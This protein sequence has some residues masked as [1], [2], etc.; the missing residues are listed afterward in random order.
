MNRIH[1]PLF[2]ALIITLLATGLKAQN[3]DFRITDVLPLSGWFNN[4]TQ[5]GGTVTLPVKVY[6]S[7]LSGNWVN[8]RIYLSDDSSKSPSDQQLASK[9][10]QFTNNAQQKT[11]NVT[12]T[13]P[14]Y[15]CTTNG[16]YF[17]AYSS[18]QDINGDNNE[19]YLFFNSATEDLNFRHTWNKN[20]GIECATGH[21]NTQPYSHEVGGWLRNDGCGD[22]ANIQLTTLLIQPATGLQ[23]Q[24]RDSE[25]NAVFHYYDVNANGKTYFRFHVDIDAD[26]PEGDY[27]IC[28]IAHTETENELD[29]SNDFACKPFAFYPTTTCS[30][31]PGEVGMT[32]YSGLK[33]NTNVLAAGPNPTQCEF[34]L[35]YEPLAAKAIFTLTDLQG[36]VISTSSLEASQQTGKL[37]FDLTNH[38]NGV[39]VIRMTSE[40]GAG[41]DV[42]RL[43]KQ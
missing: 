39:Y 5:P 36:R 26:L 25:T 41:P 33:G 19:D 2:L 22:A 24:L 15:A 32:P 30:S 43:V 11:V 1:Q 16:M 35:S 18:Y 28:W 17:I 13:M 21:D 40:D 37:R 9:Y 42:I 34:M 6:G 38:P 14:D 8:F 23:I 27:E 7:N 3:Q 20:G 12:F 4:D 29:H 10:V 31:T